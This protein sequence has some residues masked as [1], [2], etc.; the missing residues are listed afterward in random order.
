MKTAI[1]NLRTILTGDWHDPF[2]DG[3]TII[4]DEGRITQIGSA[5]SHQSR[6]V[7]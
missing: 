7:T 1:T 6:L 3:D 2:V 4:M 5:S